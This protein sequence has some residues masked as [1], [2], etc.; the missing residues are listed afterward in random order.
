MF[1]AIN[2]SGFRAHGFISDKS[3]FCFDEISDF[4]GSV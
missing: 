2:I 4:I 1:L 3:V